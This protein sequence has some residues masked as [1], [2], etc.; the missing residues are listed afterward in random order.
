MSKLKQA[1]TRASQSRHM[2]IK[3]LPVDYDVTVN[4]KVK[5]GRA[6][7][8]MNG[9]FS[10]LRDSGVRTRGLP[11]PPLRADPFGVE[12]SSETGRSTK[13]SCVTDALLVRCRVRCMC[14]DVVKFGYS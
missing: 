6:N 12:G 9:D 10:Y 8:L 5:W 2:V 3:R 7:L 11:G 13:G 14:F 4:V 1:Q